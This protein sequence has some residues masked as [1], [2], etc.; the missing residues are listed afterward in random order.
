MYAPFIIPNSPEM[1]KY[2]ASERG[3]SL[4]Y[5]IDLIPNGEFTGAALASIF[6]AVSGETTC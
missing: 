2:I 1:M 3:V 5:A 4:R 6:R